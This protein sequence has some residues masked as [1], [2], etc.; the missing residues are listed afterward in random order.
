[1]TNETQEHS[2][3]AA[4][5]E[6]THHEV[7]EHLPEWVKVFEE[8]QREAEE[9]YADGRVKVIIPKRKRPRCS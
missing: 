5:P 6:T 1:M 4:K 7:D 2:E 8:L 3:H 9:A